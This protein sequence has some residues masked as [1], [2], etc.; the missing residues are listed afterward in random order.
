MDFAS[1][2]ARLEQTELLSAAVVL[3]QDDR[4]DLMS[5]WSAAETVIHYEV[6]LK[7]SYW[8]GL[9]HLVFGVGLAEDDDQCKE[10]CSEAIRL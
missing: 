6:N 3:S 10:I 8:N 1:L 7:L 9:P 2:Q 5:D 4:S